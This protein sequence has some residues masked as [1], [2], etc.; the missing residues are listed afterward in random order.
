MRR[1]EEVVLHEV[2]EDLVIENETLVVCAYAHLHD[3]FGCVLLQDR[4]EFIDL[5]LLLSGSRNICIV[6]LP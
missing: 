1:I 5:R 4:Y 6:L 3:L 2:K